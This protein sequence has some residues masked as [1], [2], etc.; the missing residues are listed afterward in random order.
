MQIESLRIIVSTIVNLHQQPRVL[1]RGMLC[2]VVLCCVVLC[3][4]VCVKCIVSS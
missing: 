3:C 2:C 4:V 1:C